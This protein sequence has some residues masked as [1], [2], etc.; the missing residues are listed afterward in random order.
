MSLLR[1]IQARVIRGQYARL[2]RD[3]EVA[4]PE[5]L[6]ARGH[7]RVIR[8]FQRAAT[9]VPAYRRLLLEKGTDPG[10]VTSIREF[11]RSVPVQDKESVFATNSLRDLCVGGTLDGIGSVY[12]SSGQS[13]AFSFGVAAWD[14]P[15][16]SA[17]GLE[18]L[19]DAL[20]GVLERKT[21]LVNCLPMGV[22]VPTRTVPVADT[23]VRSDVVLALLGKLAEDFEQFIL[24]GE[25]LFLKKVLDEGVDQGTPWRDLCVHVVTGGEFIAENLRSYF[26]RVLGFD[27][28]DPARGAMIVNMGLSELGLSLFFET[29]ETAGI[30][31]LAHGNPAVLSALGGNPA[32]ACPAFMQYNPLSVFAEAIPNPQ[33][34]PELVVSV[35]GYDLKMPLVRY[36]T[37]DEGQLLSYLALV[38][39]L[40]Q[41]GCQALVP[42]FRL[43]CVAVSGKKRRV[44][45]GEGQWLSPD[46][47]K[48]A[49]YQ[50]HDV[51]QAITGSFRL[52][53]GEQGALV[54]IQLRRGRTAPQDAAERICVNLA[55]YVQAS[56]RV[57]LVPFAQPPFDLEHDYERKPQY[58]Q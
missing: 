43:P 46:E 29:P 22:K 51:A 49:I 24:V 20:F 53:A 4:D 11:T 30:R 55:R 37:K 54:R 13:G 31:R 18:F 14:D 1:G 3:L 58:V 56:V 42:R 10:S 5:R 27:G 17:L 48:E 45:V 36:N 52:S 41:F 44:R 2:A 8:A 50:D 19:L 21:L 32:E 23:G 57:V 34:L 6:V 25:S 35:L 28:E 39:I 15:A 38:G 16:K 47:V 26:G 33:G 12:S 9:C 40:G 7:A